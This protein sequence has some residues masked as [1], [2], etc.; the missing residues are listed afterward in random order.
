MRKLVLFLLLFFGISCL[1]QT[2]YQG[3]RKLGPKDWAAL[4]V[5]HTVSV[6]P[7]AKPCFME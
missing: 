6:S 7:D 1:C 3:R 5:A 4:R 2:P